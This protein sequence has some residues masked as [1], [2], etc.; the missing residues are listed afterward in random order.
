VDKIDVT[1]AGVDALQDRIT[2][3]WGRGWRARL[4]LWAAALA[5]PVALAGAP[6]DASACGGEI[7]RE[8]DSSTQIVARAEQL[9]VEGKYQQ[10]VAKAIQAYPALKIVKPGTLHLADRGLRI[11]ALSSVRAEGSI[12]GGNFRSGTAADRSANLEWSVATLRTL[13]GLRANNPSYQTDL[14]EALSKVPVY[15][16]E[17]S[18]ILEELASKDLLTSAEGYA[19]LAR[20]RAEAGN[21][22]GRDEAVK[23]CEAMTKNARV[24]ETPEGST[25]AGAPT[26]AQPGQT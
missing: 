4:G 19:A 20:L 5:V 8:M 7:Y 11:I 15:H 16:A 17:A 2:T 3:R 10:A 12:S 18:K 21:G 24:C 22:A 9:L 23:R 6:G 26:P 1:D 13:N 14:G 25:P